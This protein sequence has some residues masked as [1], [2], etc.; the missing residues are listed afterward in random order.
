MPSIVTATSAKRCVD[1]NLQLLG[2]SYNQMNFIDH[3]PR[4]INQVLKLVGNDI[5]LRGLDVVASSS[6][7][8]DIIFTVTPGLLIQDTTLIEI[9]DAT[10][11]TFKNADQFDAFE[12]G[13][14]VVHTDFQYLEHGRENQLKFAVSYIDCYGTSDGSWYHDKNRIVL[15]S[16]KV[17]K[18]RF[19]NISV[20]TSNFF[21]PTIKER[22]TY[23][24]IDNIPTVATGTLDGTYT[25]INYTAVN[26][27][28]AG[29][30]III[31]H[32][33]TDRV[34]NVTVDVLSMPGGYTITINMPINGA[35]SE[36]VVR[37]VNTHPTAKTI[38]TAVF[39]EFGDTDAGQIQLSG[40][41]D[42]NIDVNALHVTDHSDRHVILYRDEEVYNGYTDDLKCDRYTEIYGK[43]YHQNG[44]EQNSLSLIKYI[45]HIVECYCDCSGDQGQD[46]WT[47]SDKCPC[48]ATGTIGDFF[49]QTNTGD[50]FEKSMAIINQNQPDPFN[51]LM[52]HSCEFFGKSIFK[53]YSVYDH[54]VLKYGGIY[55]HDSIY[56][57][58]PSSIYFNNLY[59][60]PITHT[61]DL[62]YL[63]VAYNNLFQF[64]C[65]EFTMA[66]WV[67]FD[68]LSPSKEYT[69]L[70]MHESNA[71]TFWRWSYI[72]QGTWG[73]EISFRHDGGKDDTTF[74]ISAKIDLVPNQW[75]YIMLVGLCDP[76]NNRNRLIQFVNGELI[77][78]SSY[79]SFSK[80]YGPINIGIFDEND[81]MQF[82]GKMSDI[83]V[84]TRA[85]YDNSYDLNL[86]TAPSCSGYAQLMW[87]PKNTQT[88]GQ[89]TSAIVNVLYGKGPYSWSLVY[90][91]S[92]NFT[93]DYQ[94]TTTRTNVLRTNINACGSIKIMVTD[95]LGTTVNGFIRCTAGVWLFKKYSCELPYETP[96]DIPE[97]S[98]GY[99]FGYLLDRTTFSIYWM[100][101]KGNQCQLEAT[102]S[103]PYTNVNKIFKK[104]NVSP[105]ELE[106]GNCWD[107]STCY[108]DCDDEICIAPKCSKG[109]DNL[110]RSN[111]WEVKHWRYVTF[112]SQYY[113]WVCDYKRLYWD[114]DNEPIYIAPNSTVTAFIKDGVG[115]FDWTVVEG[116]MS[117]RFG[118]VQTLERFNTIIADGYVVTNQK[119]VV[120]VQDVT[121]NE[122]YGELVV[123][124]HSQVVR[125]KTNIETIVPGQNV[126]WNIKN[127]TPPF[128]WNI[129]GT[130][131]SLQNTVSNTRSNTIKSLSTARGT[132]TITVTDVHNTTFTWYIRATNGTWIKKGLG[133]P[134]RPERIQ[135]T[136]IGG[137][138]ISNTRPDGSI[139]TWYGTLFSLTA[140]KYK[141]NQ[142][143][144]RGP[145]SS[146]NTYSN[147]TVLNWCNDLVDKTTPNC[148]DF[149]YYPNAGIKCT[150][151]PF[152]MLVNLDP[153]E[154]VYPEGDMSYVYN[155]KYEYYEWDE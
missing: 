108:N 71:P 8:K 46:Q 54:E 77:S 51:I 60:N 145:T 87:D 154:K 114:I 65:S 35:T 81:P 11:I 73:S 151:S 123:T 1:I 148:I 27:G 101:I 25:R 105:K 88:I 125:D 67:N 127:G 109:V 49:I 82:S 26:P 66:M 79:N 52:I 21:G 72:H 62:Q 142:I 94:L 139:E 100:R 58:P 138:S 76:D 89:A 55:H 10:S 41:R 12:R 131:F 152:H 13:R 31:K 91:D 83:G 42:A 149:R 113:E 103:E 40:G 106:T 44:Y 15:D 85:L 132:G 124:P 47:S 29:N 78:T 38:V 20:I 30:S 126:V 141:I 39:N 104:T 5:V 28:S 134:I 146:N 56:K 133:C 53:D 19:G 95:S 129:T 97:I 7:G 70:S 111:E 63:R 93:L 4:A 143:I 50:V 120:R 24:V 137:G 9:T 64:G 112:Q 43:I 23:V 150:Y 37:A 75:N 32:I 3:L 34:F 22:I 86:I 128:T 119:C 14:F 130:G 18:D 92:S 147:D 115:P 121:R 155:V 116:G 90:N 17:K 68:Q 96:D 102:I 16:F 122:C 45:C 153:G 135:G 118:A 136:Q 33:L 61:P 48:N 110:W 74:G 6:N 69:F 99:C 107:E 2:V 59:Y 144:I 84:W 36:E 117:F 80:F 98:G 140:G 57:W